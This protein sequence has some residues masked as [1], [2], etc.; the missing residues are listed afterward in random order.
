MLTRR[1]TLIGRKKEKTMNNN[2]Y[3][4]GGNITPAGREVAQ[5]VDGFINGLKE[6]CGR[7][8]SGRGNML[9]RVGYW[10]L[11]GGGNFEPMMRRRPIAE[12]GSSD[13]RNFG[14]RR[15]HRANRFRLSHADL[16]REGGGCAARFE[17]G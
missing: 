7:S 8:K 5:R 12:V 13:T 9:D 10:L 15:A 1:P 16:G 17:V 4:D 6:V 11:L 14:G 2:W 3:D